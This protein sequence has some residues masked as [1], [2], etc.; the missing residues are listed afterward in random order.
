MPTCVRRI[1]VNRWVGSYG[2]SFGS[3]LAMIISFTVNKSVAWA[4]LHGIFSWVYVFV[5]CFC[6][7]REYKKGFLVWMLVSLIIII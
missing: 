7:L 5:L 4:I 1:Y 6:L 3:A 2:L